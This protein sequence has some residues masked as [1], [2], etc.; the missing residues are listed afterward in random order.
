M[1]KN[2]EK[3]P[4]QAR[5]D[6][7]RMLGPGDLVSLVGQ[8]LRKWQKPLGSLGLAVSQLDGMLSQLVELREN[9]C[10][11]MSWILKVHCSHM[12]THNISIL[13]YSDDHQCRHLYHWSSNDPVNSIHCFAFC[14]TLRNQKTSP[15]AVC[16]EPKSKL[17]FLTWHCFE[18]MI[19][20]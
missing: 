13:I 4:P 3:F 12:L 20:T 8:M 18:S 6:Q 5:K 2:A 19:P 15:G 16:G 7:E 10:L 9:G 14:P 1:S 11:G 17:A